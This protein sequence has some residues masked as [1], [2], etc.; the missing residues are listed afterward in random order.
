MSTFELVDLCYPSLSSVGSMLFLLWEMAKDSNY[1]YIYIVDYYRPNFGRDFSKG[2]AIVSYAATCVNLGEC[3][4]TDLAIASKFP[5]D[6]FKN[7]RT[8]DQPL[9]W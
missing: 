5:K 8:S 4:V 9:C 3:I 1:I 7:N 2:K 6:R